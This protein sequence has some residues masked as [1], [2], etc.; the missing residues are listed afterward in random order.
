MQEIIDILKTWIDF[1]RARGLT[2]KAKEFWLLWDFA[3]GDMGFDYYKKHLSEAMKILSN[4]DLEKQ[5]C[6]I[7]YDSLIEVVKKYE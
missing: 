5:Q 6:K 7:V 4:L 1:A 2:D 3:T